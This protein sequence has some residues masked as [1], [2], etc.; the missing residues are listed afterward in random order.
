MA[1]VDARPAGT[2]F[3]LSA[4]RGS[5]RGRWA[6]WSRGRPARAGGSPCCETRSRAGCSPRLTA[7]L[8][9]GRGVARGLR[10]YRFLVRAEDEPAEDVVDL[11]VSAALVDAMRKLRPG[12]GR[13]RV[14]AAGAAEYSVVEGAAGDGPP[15]ARERVETLPAFLGAGNPTVVPRLQDSETPAG[16]ARDGGGVCGGQGATRSRRRGGR[17]LPEGRCSRGVARR[18]V[19]CGSLC[20]S[21]GCTIAGMRVSG[22]GFIVVTVELSAG[23]VVEAS[24]AVGPEGSFACNCQCR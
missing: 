10:E 5:S 1:L 20:T 4:G 18:A 16:P 21:L 17:G 2:W 14:R 15:E 3:R 24:I 11:A 22:D 23:A 19:A 12:A 6:R 8:P 13:E 9:Q 7:R